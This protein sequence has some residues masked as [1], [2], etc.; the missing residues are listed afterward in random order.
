M[1]EISEGKKIGQK[2][3]RIL[4]LPLIATRKLSLDQQKQAEKYFE[5]HGYQAFAPKHV[6]TLGLGGLEG[7]SQL[8]TFLYAVFKLL[9]LNEHDAGARL[10]QQR[11][12]GKKVTTS[13]SGLW[14]GKIVDLFDACRPATTHT[15]Y[16]PFLIK[17]L[18][19]QRDDAYVF[20]DSRA[21]RE[22]ERRATSPRPDEKLEPKDK[23][24]NAM[25]RR[26]VIRPGDD[27]VLPTTKNTSALV[28]LDSDDDSYSGHVYIWP[29]DE[30][31]RTADMIGI[32]SSL[33]NL[34]CHKVE[35]VGIKLLAAALLWTQR[36]GFANLRILV[37]VQNMINVI[38]TS[39]VDSYADADQ[40]Y[41]IAATAS[42]VKHLVSQ[43]FPS[44]AADDYQLTDFGCTYPWAEVALLLSANDNKELE[45]LRNSRQLS[46]FYDNVLSFR[47]RQLP[48]YEWPSENEGYLASQLHDYEADQK[49]LASV[50]KEEEWDPLEST[51]RHASLSIL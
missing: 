49:I 37:P 43:A 44:A 8:C 46:K 3:Y 23:H 12:S 48:Y 27:W 51:C 4:A 24:N 39:K 1:S 38:S 31:E 6:A 21:A 30:Y 7:A 10:L 14:A 11:S 9:L 29:S 35:Q 36:F 40:S 33:V 13:T 16:L 15:D 34:A 5:A 22:M 42:N 47:N 32:R 45:R 18:Y 25:T 20:G 2:K 50:N 17:D 19:A 41:W 26:E 28:L